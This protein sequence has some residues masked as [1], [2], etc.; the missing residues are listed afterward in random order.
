MF[1]AQDTPS[2]AGPAVPAH[3]SESENAKNGGSPANAGASE[4]VAELSAAQDQGT[5]A[6]VAQ[7]DRDPRPEHSSAPAP[8]AETQETHAKEAAAPVEP[9]AAAAAED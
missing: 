5:A 3:D 8:Q 9:E 4:V 2:T 6:P 7:A 1:P